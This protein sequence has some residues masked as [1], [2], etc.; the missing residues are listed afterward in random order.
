[1]RGRYSVDRRV[2]SG[3]ASASMRAW[4][5]CAR[6]QRRQRG[7]RVGVARRRRRG[8]R[9]RTKAAKSGPGMSVPCT[10][11]PPRMSLKR[12]L[13]RWWAEAIAVAGEL[14]PV[15]RGQQVLQAGGAAR[16]VGQEGLDQLLG[17]VRALVSSRATSA[18]VR[19]TSATTSHSCT[20]PGASRSSGLE[21]V[22]AALAP[23]G[24]ARGQR[25]ARTRRPGARRRRGGSGCRAGRG[26]RRWW[27]AAPRAAPA[28]STTWAASVKTASEVPGAAARSACRRRAGR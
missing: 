18:W 11:T 16:H 2:R 28:R 22:R 26:S 7:E 13:A 19:A 25:L 17:P 15:G 24:V 9:R 4:W 14:Q 23:R 12:T 20:S 10:K 3:S 8:W 6:L 21:Q 5:A 1:M 27:R